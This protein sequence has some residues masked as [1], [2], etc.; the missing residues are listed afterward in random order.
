MGRFDGRIAVV[1]GAAR[2]IGLG[3]S[4]RFADEGASVAVLDLDESQAADAA[5]G[6][7][8]G[9][10]QRHLG[11]G[12]DVSDSDSVQAAVDRVVGELGGL[13]I[14]VNNAGISKIGRASCRERV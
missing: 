11:V 1:T 3:I 12:C 9:D 14:L 7:P 5:R 10:G 8:A 6:L 2:G 4:T 13:H